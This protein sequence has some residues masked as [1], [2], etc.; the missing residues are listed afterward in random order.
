MKKALSVVLSLCMLLGF[1]AVA[2]AKSPETSLRFNADG[3]FKILMMNDTQ[4]VGKGADPRCAAFIEA[5]LEQEKPDLVV[6]VGDQL[7]DVYPFAS[8]EDFALSLDNMFAPI[9]KRGIPF[10]AT[11]GNH[12]HDRER[13]L[14]EA[15]QYEIYTK[16]DCFVSTENGPEGDPFTYSVPVMSADGS[17]TV[18]NI[19]MMD[20]NNKAPEGG[21]AGVTEEQVNWYKAQSEALKAANGG[22][23]VPSLNFQHI[24]VKE[25]YNLLKKCDWNTPGSIYARRDHSWYII[26]ETKAE[27]R[28]DEAPC[29]EDFDHI[30]GQYQAWVE[31]GDIMGAYFAH[32]HID[33]FTGVTD[34]GIRMGYNGGTGFRAYGSKADRSMRVIELKESDVT[35]YTTRSISFS[36]VTGTRHAF[37]IADYFSPA[38]LTVL[39]KAVYALLGWAI[40]LAK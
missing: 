28:L 9:E 13:T 34:D 24:P 26:D 15:G 18:F 12:D 8:P 23:A 19:Y 25:V 16:Y 39:M 11:L 30:T 31:Q 29:S 7:S 38:L 22:E 1:A 40:K 33:N 5:A 14:D 20:T 32:D 10:M 3:T 17:K 27:G 2:G 36:E 37:S 4:D 21:Y 6:F 35:N